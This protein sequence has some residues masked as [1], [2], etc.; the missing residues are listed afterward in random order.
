MRGKKSHLARRRWL[1]VWRLCWRCCSGG[2]WRC[3]GSLAAAPSSGAA[4]SSGGERDS[5]SFLLCFL[6]SSSAAAFPLPFVLFFFIPCWRAFPSSLFGFPN[7]F[8]C[9]GSLSLNPVPFFFVSLV[10]FL[11][12]VFFSSVFLFVLF[13]P[14]LHFA[15][16]LGAIYRA[17]ECGFLLWRMGSRSRGGWSAIG[18]DCTGAAPPVF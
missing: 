11:S 6:S 8:L 2:R 1:L 17:S 12:S 10:S 16:V 3:R 13:S 9:F 15:A 18:R 14:S 5:S 7:G 4:V